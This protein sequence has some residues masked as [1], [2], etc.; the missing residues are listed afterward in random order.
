V[1]L[2]SDPV[3]VNVRPLPREDELPGFTGAIGILRCDPP[4]LATNFVRVG[5]PLKLTVTV[6][7]E[8]SLSRLTAPP[9][10]RARGW[11]VFGAVADDATPAPAGQTGEVRAFTYTLIPL[12]EEARATPAIPFCCFDPGRTRYVDLT[13]PPVPLTV[14]PGG[15]PTDLQ[16]LRQLEGGASEQEEPSRISG[17]ARTPGRTAASL[18]PLQRRGWFLFVQLAPALL[19]AGLWAGDR[20]R[21]HLEAHPDILLRRRARRALRREWRALRRAADVGD[22]ARFALC[23]VNA[24]RVACAPRYP[25]EP[26]A[27][28]CGDVLQ[29]LEEPGRPN[30]FSEVVRRFF[31]VTDA[32]RFANVSA[33]ATAL[34]ALQSELEHVLEQLEARL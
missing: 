6:H 25:A 20:R 15:V 2:D 14:R 18:V 16:A 27:L 5:E 1:L 24:M 29:L 23:A 13:I 21:R 26:R 4:T 30:R 31:A 22:A 10:P 34:L 3:T 7:G 28:V 17:L 11:Q 33:D 12:T 9:P 32:S 8:G 19:F